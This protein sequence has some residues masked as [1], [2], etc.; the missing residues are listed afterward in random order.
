VGLTSAEYTLIGTAVGA[1]LTQVGTVSTSVVNYRRKARKAD[2]RAKV[3]QENK[4]RPL[5]SALIEQAGVTEDLLNKVCKAI[6]DDRRTPDNWLT[7]LDDHLARIDDLITRIRID[8]SEAARD[9]AKRINVRV[10]NMGLT[11]DEEA[12]DEADVFADHA[13]RAAEVLDSARESL[14]DLARQEFNP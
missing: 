5:Y 14:I 6:R 2:G 8:G 13:E 9:V 12:F 3:E 10:I 4:R 7:S 1:I 11:T